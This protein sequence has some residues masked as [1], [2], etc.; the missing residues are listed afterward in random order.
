[1][2]SRPDDDGHPHMV[3]ENAWL[4]E[5]NEE[6]ASQPIWHTSWK[7]NRDLPCLAGQIWAVSAGQ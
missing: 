5:T 1:M 7:Q 4:T 2:S 3:Q 6:P